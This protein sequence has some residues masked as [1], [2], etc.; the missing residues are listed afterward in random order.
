MKLSIVAASAV[1]MCLAAAPVAQAEGKINPWKQCGIGAII[2]DDNGTA[3]AISNIIWDL[4]TTAVLS[5]ISS[6][7]ACE[8]KNVAAAQFIN[9]SIVN[10]EEETVIGQGQHLTAMLNILG[11]EAS[12]HP[13]IISAVRTDL[14]LSIADNTAKAEAY[15]LQLEDK[16]SGQFAEN[17]QVI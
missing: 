2:F 8:G 14:N 1:V 4:G 13:V 9:D 7:G 16:T 5:N 17:C 6:P 12:V 10:I 3:A 15:Y 11:C